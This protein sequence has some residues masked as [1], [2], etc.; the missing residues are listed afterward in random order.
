MNQWLRSRP[1][2]YLT[3]DLLDLLI[4][5]LGGAGSLIHDLLLALL[6]LV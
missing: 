4:L 2:I 1:K 5:V 3:Y 6:I